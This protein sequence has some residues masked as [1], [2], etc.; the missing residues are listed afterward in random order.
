MVWDEKKSSE[1]IL[2]QVISG[3]PNNSLTTKEVDYAVAVG[4]EMIENKSA[5]GRSWRQIADAGVAAVKV[6]RNS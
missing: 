3:T 1:R 2:R 6:K 4:S 5:R